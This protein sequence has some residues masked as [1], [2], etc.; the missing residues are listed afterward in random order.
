MPDEDLTFELT[1]GQDGETPLP[2]LP[3]APPLPRQRQQ[4]SLGKISLDMRYLPSDE[5]K[6]RVAQRGSQT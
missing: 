5:M 4:G 1:H 6:D 2:A 3:A